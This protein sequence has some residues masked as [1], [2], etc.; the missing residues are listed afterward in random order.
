MS[1]QE[2]VSESKDID[3]SSDSAQETDDIASLKEDN[4]TCSESATEE[5][6]H[7]EEV[8]EVAPRASLRGAERPGGRLSKR[9]NAPPG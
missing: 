6:G 7:G 9:L 8:L 4:D 3:F 1:G 2:L 5:L